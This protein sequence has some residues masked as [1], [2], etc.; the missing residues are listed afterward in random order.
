MIYY[1][2]W[3]NRFKHK[4][5]TKAYL[6]LFLSNKSADSFFQYED[7]LMCMSSKKV[8]YS[9]REDVSMLLPICID[10]ATNLGTFTVIFVII[11]DFV[12][13]IQAKA[14]NVTNIFHVSQACKFLTSVASKDH[15]SYYFLFFLCLICL[16]IYTLIFLLINSDVFACQP[17][18]LCSSFANQYLILLPLILSCY[19]LFD[20]FIAEN[21]DEKPDFEL[22][23][24]PLYMSLNVSK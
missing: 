15:H 11:Y 22:F 6:C 17:F 20:N 23:I 18:A 13:F 16:Y 24:S 5:S 8:S 12:I 1:S 10:K 4:L 7:R 14:F 2:I 9:R 19:C 3:T 21:S